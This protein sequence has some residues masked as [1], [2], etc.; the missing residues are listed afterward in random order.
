MHIKVDFELQEINTQIQKDDT[1]NFSID[2]DFIAIPE[3]IGD[4]ERVMSELVQAHIEDL[5][6]YNRHDYVGTMVIVIAE[7]LGLT[8]E[9]DDTL[10]EDYY[11][12]QKKKE[13]N[14]ESLENDLKYAISIMQSGN[15]E[16][17]VQALN[18]VRF[19][20]ESWIYHML[21]KHFD[22]PIPEPYK[23]DTP[24]SSEPVP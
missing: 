23:P 2:F 4:V 16:N 20:S 11:E 18:R 6:L 19:E 15:T 9:K 13:V 8:I 5:A 17:T 3:L 14:L 10:T 24:V 7:F 21:N 1:T 22:Q 12:Q